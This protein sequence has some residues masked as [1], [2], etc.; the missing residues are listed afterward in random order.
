MKSYIL[1]E[2]LI[3]YA[4]HGVFH[5]ETTVGNV[6]V[7]NIKIELDLEPASKSDN[8]ND[9]ISYADV[10]ESVKQEMMIPSRLLEHVAGRII[11]RLKKEY[12]QI[13]T[14]EVKLSKRNPPMGGQL[15]YASVILID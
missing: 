14:L 13:E 9:T 6:Y 3:F 5:Q 4:H 12:T 11:R 8:L 1:L 2:N 10:Y 15:D 7:L